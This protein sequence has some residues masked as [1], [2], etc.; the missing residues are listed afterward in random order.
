MKAI[1]VESLPARFGR[2][3]GWNGYV[4]QR[5]TLQDRKAPLDFV[6]DVVWWCDCLV[7]SSFQRELLLKMEFLFFGVGTRVHFLR[8]QYRVDAVAVAHCIVYS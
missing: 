6:M 5:Q 4:L 7:L 2:T 3:V 8:A 1:P